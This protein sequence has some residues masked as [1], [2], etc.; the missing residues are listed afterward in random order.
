MSAS[1][2]IQNISLSAGDAANATTGEWRFEPLPSNLTFVNGTL[3]N[4]TLVNGMIYNG[5]AINGTIIIE[6]LSSTTVGSVQLA[7][8]IYIIMSIL[9]V[10]MMLPN[11][12]KWIRAASG[13]SHRFLPLVAT[14]EFR[15]SLFRSQISA[16]YP[17]AI[18]IN[19]VDSYAEAVA[20]KPTSSVTPEELRKCRQLLRGKYSLDCQIVNLRHVF[21]PNRHIVEGMKKRSNGACYDLKRMVSGWMQAQGQWSAEEW[22]L[23]KKIS[24]RVS[25]IQ[26]NHGAVPKIN[27]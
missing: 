6:R 1:S 27:D 20:H 5:S 22:E 4:G 15:E 13:H 26:P 12:V 19:P 21:E 25:S 9:I 17:S 3:K 7:S 23:V 18:V 8:F 16:Y 2:G 11:S 14:P 24:E 10:L